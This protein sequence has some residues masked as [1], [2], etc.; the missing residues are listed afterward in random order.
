MGKHDKHRDPSAIISIAAYPKGAVRKYRS[1]WVLDAEIERRHPHIIQARILALHRHRQYRRF[2]VES[3]QFQELF[4]EHIQEA[5]LDDPELAGLHIEKL[6][7]HG[8]KRLRIQKCGPFINFGRL[9]FSRKVVSLFVQ[10]RD[11]P[12]A[13]HDDGPDATELTLETIGAIGSRVLSDEADMQQPKHGTEFEEQISRRYGAVSDDGEERCGNCAFHTEHE[14]KPWCGARRFQIKL[15]DPSCSSWEPMPK[16][17][18][19]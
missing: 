13:D 19:G 1:Y 17:Q 7:P 6:T 14:G 3:V 9:K 2:G 11:Y 15:S 18:G 8:D 5:T 16:R 10:F 4:A 12:E